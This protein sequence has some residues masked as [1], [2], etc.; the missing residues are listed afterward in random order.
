MS[1]PVSG[2]PSFASAHRS[3]TEGDWVLL[4]PSNPELG[5]RYLEIMCQMNRATY[6]CKRPQRIVYRMARFPCEYYYLQGDRFEVVCG[7]K[8][9]QRQRLFRLMSVGFVGAI[10]PQDALDLVVQNFCRFLFEKRIRSCGGHSSGRHGKP[11]DRRV[12]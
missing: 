5:Y 10:S 6:A 9:H 4:T 12:L 1:F 3:Q 7:Y 8:W 2:Y 11:G